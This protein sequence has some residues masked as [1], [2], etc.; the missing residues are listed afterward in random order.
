MIS[1][2]VYLYH[3]P[4]FL[5]LGRTTGL[6][7]WTLFTVQIAVTLA[8]SLAS[9][10]VV[11]RP[12][13]RG[14]LRWP[15]PVV[16]VPAT[17][18]AV[19]TS[20]VAVTAGYVPVSAT[21]GRPDSLQAVTKSMTEKPLGA[22]RLLVLGNSVPFFLAREGFEQLTTSPPLLVLD[23]AFPTCAF[24]PEATTFR[25]I[26]PN[27]AVYLPLPLPCTQGWAAD[28][29]T[30]RPNVVLFTMGDLLGE[31][32]D[33]TDGPWLRPCTP[34]FDDW[35]AS[36]LADA[37]HELT[38]DG[39]RL[40]IATS[41]Y[42][43]YFG[44]PVGRWSQTDCMN[45]VEHAV[46]AEYPGVV[47][48]IDLGRYVCPQFGV[49]RQTI[50]GA[51]MRPDGIHYRGRSAQAIAAWLLPQMRFGPPGTGGTTIAIRKTH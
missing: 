18:I 5:W 17:V 29:G 46:G 12:I 50:D 14:V 37:V 38:R 11:E 21:V 35:F 25:L 47:S 13:R 2:G 31:L 9:Y 33:G 10:V 36:S 16:V 28:V 26:Q 45:R 43:Q 6:A 48:V 7:G 41:A 15:R 22:S 8:V 27:G 51:P 30:F 3:W 19:V 49:C 32:R 44:A 34:G 4:I 42:S 40:V 23:G 24:P 20:L 39:A 1:Y